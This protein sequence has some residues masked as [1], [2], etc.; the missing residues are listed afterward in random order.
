MKELPKTLQVDPLHEILE[1]QRKL[2]RQDRL[3]ES[4]RKQMRKTD[5]V[6]YSLQLFKKN[7][8]LKI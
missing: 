1:L 7:L 3:L 8:E 2:E 6:L 5:E 4:L